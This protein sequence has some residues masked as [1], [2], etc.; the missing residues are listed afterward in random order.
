[1]MWVSSAPR[2]MA[3]SLAVVGHMRLVRAAKDLDH[4]RLAAIGDEQ[5]HT[6]RQMTG[7]AFGATVDVEDAADLPF[8]R[9]FQRLGREPLVEA[10]ENVIA[11]AQGRPA[12]RARVHALRHLAPEVGDPVDQ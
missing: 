9:Q 7:R 5:M 3:M 1:M 2:P 8:D 10:H 12:G 4:R 11:L 6:V